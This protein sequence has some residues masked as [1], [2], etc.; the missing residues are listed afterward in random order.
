MSSNIYNYGN[1]NSVFDAELNGSSNNYA[2]AISGKDGIIPITGFNQKILNNNNTGMPQNHSAMG[3]VGSAGVGQSQGHSQSQNGKFYVSELSGNVMPL[4]DFKHNNMVPFYRGN[5]KQNMDFDSNR[6]VLEKF[7]GVG[8]TYRKK[9][10]VKSMFDVTKTNGLVN[11]SNAFT[12]REGIN[13]RFI[14]SQKRQNE[15]PIEQ[16]RVGPGLADGYTSKPSGGF[17]QSSAREYILPKNVDELR[18]G[19]RQK[20]SELEGRINPGGLP[21]G[22]RGKVGKVNKNKVPTYYNNTPDKY[23]KN[24]GYI[25]AAAMREKFYAKP[26]NR[27]QSRPYYGSLGPVE[28]SKGYKVGAIRK[29]RRNNYITQN[30]RNAVAKDQWI[31][32]DKIIEEGMGDY[33]K[34]SIEN[35]PNE[36]DI[37]QKRTIIHNLTTEVKKI[38]IPLLDYAR[39]TKKENF[40]GNMRPEG[41]MKAQM[42]EKPTIKD[43]DDVLRTTIKETTI[44]NNHEGF[45]KG[46]EMTTVQSDDVMRTTIKETNIHN[47]APYINLAPQQPTNLR[48]YDPE[49]IPNTTL[50]ETTIYDHYGNVENPNVEAAGA[51]TTNNIKMKNTNKQ[52]TSDW[53]YKGIATSNLEEGGGRGY[54]T[55]RYKAKHTNKQFTSNYEYG[56]IAGSY[57]EKP[58]SYS[59]KYNMRLNPNKQEIARGRSP[60]KQGV[61]VSNGSDKINVHHKKIEGDQVNIRPPSSTLVYQAPPQ[62]NSCGLTT[63]KDKLSEDTQRSRLDGNLLQAFNDNPYTQSLSSAL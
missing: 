26:N 48:V 40:I 33:G 50:K 7:T 60:T 13:D 52:F 24:G 49:D 10:E 28:H 8:D 21:A 11:G 61:K 3:S 39:K 15:R 36:R 18:P 46:N 53:E 56:G 47:N 63:M 57:Q 27:K 29:S 17:Q 62:I 35:K 23:F 37:T 22:M 2:S 19:N 54:L 45:I 32:S 59:D 5:L 25:K 9:A 20:A 51:Y 42:P 34:E 55:N 6:T 44:H 1:L 16:I 14:P 43:P 12:S 41:N 4:E 38:M 31:V 58:M 30:P